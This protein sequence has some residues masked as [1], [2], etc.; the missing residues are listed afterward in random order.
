MAFYTPLHNPRHASNGLLL[1]LMIA[2]SCTGST[3]REYAWEGISR[4]ILRVYVRIDIPGE[5][6]LNRSSGEMQE[7]LI[8][9]AG[10]R[11]TLILTTNVRINIDD[12]GLAAACRESLPVIIR[13]GS[14]HHRRCGE[15]Y[16]TAYVD[17]D[18]GICIGGSTSHDDD[19]SVYRNGKE[20]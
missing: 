20:Q 14:L 7:A 1:M 3:V 2:C 19:Q 18:P 15:L 11:A 13:G 17:Y 16:C 12:P 6:G 9:A 10:L 8:A 5:D 4:R